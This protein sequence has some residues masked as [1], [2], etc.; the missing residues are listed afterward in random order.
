MK[1]HLPPF[2]ALRAFEAVGRQGGIRS[3]ARQL[4][5]S[6]AIVSRHVRALEEFLGATL[7]DRDSGALTAVGHDYH[8]RLSR[9]FAELVDATVAVQGRRTGK[10][11]ISCTPGLALHWLAAR[12]ATNE[13]GR[14]ISQVDLRSEDGEP[15]LAA[16]GID[17]DIRY[18]RD[19]DRDRRKRGLRFLELA[20]PPVFPVASPKLL[21]RLGGGIDSA[22]DLVRMPLIEEGNDIEWRWWMRA[23]GVEGPFNSLIGRYAHAH[24]AL[25]AA[26]AGQ[27][28]A[29]A[30]HYL[31]S[32]DLAAGRLVRVVP[33]KRPF[34]PV[35]LGAY[36]LRGLA[37]RWTDPSVVRFRRWIAGEFRK[38]PP[39]GGEPVMAAH[40]SDES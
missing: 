10:L 37:S 18:E 4:G 28:F 38:D 16:K 2:A 12:I 5:V 26:R 22:A 13:P 15:D 21:D 7:L 25:A 14:F 31:I 34:V 8:S 40:V 32:E 36:V 3:A 35:A 30:N 23:Q 11:V 27:G 20:R 19:A 6:H 9:I 17:G 29:I 33:A 39:L 1:G 24:L